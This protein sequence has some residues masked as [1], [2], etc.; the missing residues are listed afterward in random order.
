MVRPLADFKKIGTDI[1]AAPGPAGA[2]SFESLL[3]LQNNHGDPFG[4]SNGGGDIY[5]IT[6]SAG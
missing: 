1:L 2:V 3:D 6:K 5:I 4:R